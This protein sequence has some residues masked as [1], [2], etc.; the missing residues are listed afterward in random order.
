MM[1]LW[2]QKKVE[3]TGIEPVSERESNMLSTCLSSL[4][5]S[6]GG[7]T[8]ATYQPPYLLKSSPCRCSTAMTIPDIA[9]PILARLP[10][11]VGF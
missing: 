11:G 7:K 1:L 5:F 10:Q 8:E 3:L 4:R 6:C 2:V 9:A